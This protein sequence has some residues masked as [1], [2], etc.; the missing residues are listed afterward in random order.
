MALTVRNVKSGTATN[1][2]YKRTNRFSA[3]GESASQLLQGDSV[4]VR[5]RSLSIAL[6]RFFRLL[7]R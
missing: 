4:W 7:V 2:K 3:A 5:A 1:R 6:T